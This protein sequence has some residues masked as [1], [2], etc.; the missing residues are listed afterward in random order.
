MNNRLFA[1]ALWLAGGNLASLVG[2]LLLPREE[3]LF[4]LLAISVPSLIGIGAYFRLR[5]GATIFPSIAL[6][7]T[8]G[9]LVS[10]VIPSFYLVGATLPELLDLALAP[11]LDYYPDVAFAALFGQSAYLIGNSISFPDRD[12][13]SLVAS[14]AQAAG[15]PK[16]LTSFMQLFGILMLVGWVS[17]VLLLLSGSYYHQARTDFQETQVAAYSSLAQ[18]SG[19]NLYWMVGAWTLVFS[20]IDSFKRKRWVAFAGALTA[21]EFAWLFPAGSREPILLLTITILVSFV[22]ARKR[23]PIRM[24]LVAAPAMLAAIVFMGIYREII[25]TDATSLTSISVGEVES[26]VTDSGASTQEAFLSGSWV[27]IAARPSDSRP[28]AAILRDVP[29][30]VSYL[31]GE[32]YGDVFWIFVPRFLYPNKPV[33]II[34]INKWFFGDEGGS[35]PT[36]LIGEG[37]LNFGWIGIFFALLLVGIVSGA[38]E[39]YLLS[40][41]SG[42]KNSFIW[43]CVFGVTATLFLRIY[44]MTMSVYLGLVIKALLVGWVLIFIS[45][46]QVGVRVPR[47]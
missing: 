17:R 45:S 32:T 44:G 20:E 26:S 9:T 46:L 13:Q 8:I 18:L 25:R 12:F 29:A 37:F 39:R 21:M 11:Y 36:T 23:I 19:L 40:K 33:T 28:V 15:S 3:I 22:V 35:S 2:L 34:P 30:L 43:C 27:S 6:T 7:A 38:L 31:D 14:T 1:S 16:S 24:L 47:R 4:R 10:F 41:I 5:Q 42:S